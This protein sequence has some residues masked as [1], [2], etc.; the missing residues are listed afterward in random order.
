MVRVV[1]VL[2]QQCDDQRRIGLPWIKVRDK[3]IGYR[4]RGESEKQS[5]IVGSLLQ[6]I[7]SG[8]GGAIH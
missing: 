7:R 4:L 2:L 6:I 3:E 8:V 1:V 5:R